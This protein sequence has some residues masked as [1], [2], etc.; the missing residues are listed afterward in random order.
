MISLEAMR[1]VLIYME[2]DITNLF[3]CVED[4]GEEITTCN[5]HIYDS[6]QP[7]IITCS[8]GVFDMQSR[9]SELYNTMR[10]TE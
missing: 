3:D 10:A 5:D 8:D 6:I 4:F 9:V 2:V 7:G 1:E